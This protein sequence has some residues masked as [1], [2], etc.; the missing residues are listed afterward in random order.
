MVGAIQWLQAPLWRHTMA[1][2]PLLAPWRHGAIVGAI[3]GAIGAIVGAIGAI[4]APLLAPLGAMAPLWRHG[5]IGAIVAP[6]TTLRCQQ[7]GLPAGWAAPGYFSLGQ[8][9]RAAPG[10]FRGSGQD[11]GPRDE[12]PA[13]AK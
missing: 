1:P 8:L 9:G 12:N 10:F 3:V 13:V 5:A 2:A 7:P 4:V 11:V 6:L